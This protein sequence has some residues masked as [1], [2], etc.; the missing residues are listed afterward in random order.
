MSSST[1][2]TKLQQ[3]AEQAR[4]YPRR[5]FTTLAH[6]IDVD[7]LR[8]AYRRTRKSSAPGVDGVTAK[9]YAENLESNLLSLH[10]RLRSGRYQAPPVERV[11][12]EK[13]DGKKRPIGKPTFEDKIVQRAVV[14]LLEAI[15]EQDFYDFSHGFR[16]NRSPHRALKELRQQCVEMRIGWIVDADISSFF[17]SIDRS[18]LRK[19]IQVRVNDG[20]L[21]SLIGKWLNAGVMDEGVWSRPEAGTPQGGVVS[22][23]LANVFLH[24]VL[25]DWFVKAVRPRMKG[26]CF[27]IRFA[28]DFV[29]G[30]ELESDAK[31]IMEVLPKRFGRFG[32]SIHPEKSKLLSFGKP[33]RN[34]T[35]GH[36]GCGTFDFLGFTHDW[37]RS[38]Q[39]YWVIKRK[40]ASKRQR[41]A[42]K[43]LW[44]WCRRN[45]H[46]PIPAQH[47]QLSLKLQGHFLYYY[48]RGNY[49]QLD[50]L[51]RFVERA[52][53]YWLS[54]RS[55]RGSITWEKFARLLKTFPLP[56]P[57]RVYWI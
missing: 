45:R 35:R 3:I 7:L 8:E 11:W 38:R 15:Y 30:C 48:I 49:R 57:E 5:V 28:D 27:L 34:E 52:W 33:S 4:R 12:L 10:E 47:K 16:R 54:R 37:A 41:R 21:L 13:E 53:R 36:G 50:L 29:I 51:R 32:L 44:E 39:G 31:R 14:M 25:D 55:Q 20:S 6:H 23:I 26:Q 43:A 9:Q 56:K 40:T 18:W 1:V 42:K 46:L 22:P 19:C 17:D 24:Y 2:S